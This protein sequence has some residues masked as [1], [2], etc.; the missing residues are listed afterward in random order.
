MYT[1][2]THIP[3]R[4]A[5]IRISVSKSYY[6]NSLKIVLTINRFMIDSSFFARALKIKFVKNKRDKFNDYWQLYFL[7]IIYFRSLL[8]PNDEKN[9]RLNTILNGYRHNRRQS[10][11]EPRTFVPLGRKASLTEG[12]SAITNQSDWQRVVG[13]RRLRSYSDSVN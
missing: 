11:W 3:G 2:H 10:F 1:R 4:R 5:S 9:H 7:N 13:L 12:E 8:R 6:E